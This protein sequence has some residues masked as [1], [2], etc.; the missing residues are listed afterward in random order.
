MH[1][2]QAECKQGDWDFSQPSELSNQ[3]FASLCSRLARGVGRICF[4]AVSSVL[5]T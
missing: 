4:G 2:F 1:E 3:D 5:E